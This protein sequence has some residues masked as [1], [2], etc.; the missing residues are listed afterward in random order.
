MAK[1]KHD[2]DRCEYIA[3]DSK[4]GDWYVCSSPG[5]IRTLT[6]RY[7]D[8]DDDYEFSEISFGEFTNLERL[9]AVMGFKFTMKEIN[10]FG[11]RYIEEKYKFTDILVIGFHLVKRI[12]YLNCDR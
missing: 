8:G 11:L 9:A 10:R 5:D 2:C 6:R 1:W 4:G 12:C 3:T 7:G